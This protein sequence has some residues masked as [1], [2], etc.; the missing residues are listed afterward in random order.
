M[1]TVRRRGGENEFERLRDYRRDD[2]YRAIDWKATARRQKLITREYQHESNQTVLCMLDAGRLMT[3][4][5]AGLSLLDHALNAMLMLS[6]VAARAGDQVGLLAFADGIERY[7]PPAGGAGRR[8]GSSRRGT[9][10]TR[11]WSRPIMRRPSSSS[12]CACG[13]AAWW[14]SSRRSSTTLRR[15][16]CC[17]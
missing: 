11:I 12:G 9:I 1:R 14:C 3:A 8:G 16:S 6:H 7:A 15:R 13:S 17:G 2:D 10:S 4:R 5:T